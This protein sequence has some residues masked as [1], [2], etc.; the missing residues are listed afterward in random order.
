MVVK[1][2]FI[3]AQSENSQPC[4]W[5]MMTHTHIF[6]YTQCKYLHTSIM[7]NNG[8][9]IIQ[10]GMRETNNRLNKAS[11]KRLKCVIP[12]VW[13]REVKAIEMLLVE[14]KDRDRGSW[15]WVA[16][17]FSGFFYDAMM[18]EIHYSDTATRL[19]LCEL[20][21]WH[22]FTVCYIYYQI[23]WICCTAAF[24]QPAPYEALFEFKVL[25][26]HSSKSL[27][28]SVSFLDVGHTEEILNEKAA[29]H[30]L[31]QK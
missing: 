7:K 5:W 1:D 10:E 12:M 6:I 13:P 25:S 22:C 4:I 8:A 17:R 20:Q 26:N 21:P 23:V 2:F 31:K 19:P 29:I 3:I 15:Y 18:V 11:F 9:Q 16:S 28:Q 27:T 14:G 30:S 24:S